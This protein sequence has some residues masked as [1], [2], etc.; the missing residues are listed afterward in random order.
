[1]INRPAKR[2]PA[3]GSVDAVE[4]IDDIGSDGGVTAGVGSADVEIG[5]LGQIA[6]G[7]EVFYGGHI[8]ALISAEEIVG[9]AAKDLRGAFEKS[10][11][12]SGKD[13]AQRQAGV[14]DAIFTADQVIGHQRSIGPGKHVV[15]QRVDL[16]ESGAHFAHAKLEMAWQGREGDEAFLQVD[17]VL[18][19]AD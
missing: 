7:A 17:A 4:L 16:A 6:V 8:T 12:G 11:F 19:E 18:A 10:A 3:D 9:V 1:M 15:V 14:I 13:A 2:F 5:G